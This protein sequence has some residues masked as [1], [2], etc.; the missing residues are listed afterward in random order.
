MEDYHDVIHACCICQ[1]Q[2]EARWCFCRDKNAVYCSTE[3]QHKG[4]P[5]HKQICSWK[6]AQIHR[7]RERNKLDV[8]LQGKGQLNTPRNTIQNNHHTPG[9]CTSTCADS[10]QVV[11]VYLPPQFQAPLQRQH[12]TAMDDDLCGIRRCC[13]CNHWDEAR[14]C[15]CRDKKAVYC[16]IDCQREAWAEHKKSCT[17]YK[18]KLT[19]RS[20]R[21]A[22]ISNSET[23]HSDRQAIQD[24]LDKQPA[25][26]ELQMREDNAIRFSQDIE[27]SAE[28]IVKLLTVGSGVGFVGQRAVLGLLMAAMN[29]Q[30]SHQQRLGQKYSVAFEDT[31]GTH[32]NQVQG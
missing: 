12:S 8:S 10:T 11:N 2:A 26:A 16:S 23:Q 25:P 7:R 24:Q 27:K 18:Y 5:V 9:P 14:W 19:S 31:L 15:F 6:V 20:Q 28:P 29:V 13:I 30:K 32:Q 1:R 3:C 22:S 17:W 4:W 21:C